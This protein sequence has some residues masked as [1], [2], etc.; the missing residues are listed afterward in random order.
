MKSYKKTLEYLFNQLPMYQ[1]E[2][3]RAF[4]KDLTNIKALC[5]YLGNPQKKFKS[6]HVG[7]TN[8][9]GSVSHILA[10]VLQTAN[11]KT[12]L[13]TSP[14]LKD[15]RERIRINGCL[16][17][18]D[19]VIDF[20]EDN[21]YILDKIR[22]SFF[23]ISV[24]AAFLYFAEK[25]VD[26]AVIEVGLGGRLDST[27]ILMP[28]LSVITNI[29]IDHTQILGNTVKKIANE[30]AGIIKHNIPIVIG[31]TSS[32]TRSV[33]IEKAEDM[34]AQI[35]LADYLYSAHYRQINIDNK[36]VF[37]IYKGGE[38]FFENIK[39]DLLG[40]Y[41]QKNIITALQAIDILKTN[42]TISK[43]D[44]YEGFANV[45][46]KTGI[47]G[48]WQIL[49][50]EPLIISDT[51]HNEDGISAVVKQMETLTYKKLHF[52]Y[53]AVNDK[54]LDKILNLLPRKAEY[55][56]TEANIPRAFDRYKL[57]EQ[58]EK[59]NL[60]G[61]TYP[62]VKNALMSAKSKAKTNDLI[63]VGGSTFVVTE[64]L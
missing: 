22:P 45:I 37:N 56:F 14:H 11:Y 62:S 15:Y 59:F 60:K 16:V 54:K 40:S 25:M 3:K 33:F 2:G 7:G 24:A 44:M 27:N 38:L 5:K 30:K 58:A 36:Q 43:D 1:R 34:N 10:S 9:K 31:E 23:E 17:S 61:K 26:F 49:G 13:Y 53:G 55:Y 6:I 41:Q 46:K 48:R 39:T 64:V 32:K 12:G 63:F 20:V 8:G 29:G 28:I 19:F 4:K 57:K 42:F 35:Y 21:K 47:R 50:K 51:G 18:K 52:V